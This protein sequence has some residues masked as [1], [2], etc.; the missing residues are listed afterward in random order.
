MQNVVML[1]V[2]VLC[3]LFCSHQFTSIEFLGVTTVIVT[4]I[5]RTTISIVDEACTLINLPS[6]NLNTVLMAVILLIVKALN[7]DK[8]HEINQVYY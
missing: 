6:A 8:L 7:L 5:S 2:V 4:T 1:S 3:F